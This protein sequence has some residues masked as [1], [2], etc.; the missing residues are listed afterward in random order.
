MT[1]G[2]PGTGIGGLF[3]LISALFMPLRE[4][5]LT[6]RGQ[7]SLERWR[8]VAIQTIIALGII[9]GIWLMGWALGYVIAIA[10]ASM[11]NFGAHWVLTP[12]N[13]IRLAP[14][15]ITSLTLAGVLLSVHL[16]R[17]VL[18]ISR[19]LRR[20]PV[21]SSIGQTELCRGTIRIKPSY[22]SPPTP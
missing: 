16:L 14:V 15:V 17:L 7:S 6:A 1:A 8:R 18:W 19:N 12:V 21:E 20:S 11:H 22:R 2:L 4:L 13:V 3:Y 9:L 10:S 5:V